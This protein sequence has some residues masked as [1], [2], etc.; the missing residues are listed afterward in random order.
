MLITN[1]MDKGQSQQNRSGAYL[2]QPTGYAAFVPKP[3]PPI[4]PIRVDGEM[5]TLLSKADRALGRLDTPTCR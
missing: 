5:Q 4:P 2:A 3:L 1:K